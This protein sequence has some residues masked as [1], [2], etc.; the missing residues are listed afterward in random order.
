MTLFDQRE[1]A[2][3][4]KFAR[5]EE[6]RFLAAVRHSKLLG[7]WAAEQLG[8]TAVAA[9]RYTQELIDA[10]LDGLGEGEIFWKIRAVFDSSGVKQ[11]DRRIRW[12]MMELKVKAAEQI[13]L[14]KLPSIGVES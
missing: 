3:E 12:I 7:A 14:A 5:D 13:G 9:E 4:A 6:M 2:F 11:S 8:F 10:A 1:R